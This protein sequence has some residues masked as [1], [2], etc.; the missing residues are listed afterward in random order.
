MSVSGNILAE[1][2]KKESNN[3]LD[4][5]LGYINHVPI[6]KEI[7]V[8]HCHFF[9]DFVSSPFLCI[10]F[11]SALVIAPL[12]NSDNVGLQV[13]VYLCVYIM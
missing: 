12:T 13:S 11:F 1:F 6:L 7:K 5:R 3:H 8:F 10:L 4:R 2:K 9:L